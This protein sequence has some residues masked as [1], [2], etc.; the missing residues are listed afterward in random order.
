MAT[1]DD[2][3]ATVPTS[4]VERAYVQC[5]NAR[6]QYIQVGSAATDEETMNE[7]RAT[8]HAS[9]MAW[10]EAL[11]PHMADRPGEVGD[12]WHEAP[13][14]PKRPAVEVVP[15]CPNCDVGFPGDQYE[16]GD[17]CVECGQTRLERG[18]IPKLGDDGQQLYEWEVGLKSLE[19]WFRKTETAK[20]TT[21]TFRP[22]EQTVEMP[23]RLKPAHL[24][25]IARY[26][27]KAAEEMDLLADTAEALP[28]GEL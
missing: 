2:T 22:T 27:D 8:L 15:T 23:R 21:G 1:S 28:L 18:T 4:A 5:L 11:H 14:W 19:E 9:V 6:Q 20:E 12:Y 17:V 13:L 24:F 10:Y 7:L 26:L 3:G 16:I 25:R